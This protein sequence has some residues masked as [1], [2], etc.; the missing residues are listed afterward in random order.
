MHHSTKIRIIKTAYEK[1]ERIHAT[2]PNVAIA[3]LRKKNIKLQHR[4]E[5]KPE[6]K[7]TNSLLDV[8]NCSVKKIIQ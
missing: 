7:Y 3:S 5:K 6:T 2:V 4:Y 1:I 8:V